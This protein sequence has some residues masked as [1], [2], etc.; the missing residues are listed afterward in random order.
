MMGDITVTNTC[1]LDSVLTL[2]FLVWKYGDM[3]AAKFSVDEKLTEVLALIDNG[4]FDRARHYW[5]F[6]SIDINGI[7]ELE[8]GGHVWNV[9]G[10]T[11]MYT[12]ASSLF[13]MSVKDVFERC[14]EE[15]TKPNYSRDAE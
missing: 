9:N 8:L 10:Q 15:K 1:S 11:C 3:T 12:S 6:H 14:S 13:Q 5:L 7:C 2:L 4:E